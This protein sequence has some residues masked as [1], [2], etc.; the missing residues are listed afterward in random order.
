MK[1]LGQ[2]IPLGNGQIFL[3]VE[4]FFQGL[5]LNACERRSS[6][7]NFVN[8]QFVLIWCGGNSLVA[9]VFCQLNIFYACVC[10][11]VFIF[12]ICNTK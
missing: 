3:F 7:A 2:V 12:L 10:D 8:V 1:V 11:C 4:F 5:E 6:P 9:D